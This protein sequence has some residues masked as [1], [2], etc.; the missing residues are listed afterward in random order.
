MFDIAIATDASTI[1]V[2]T[3]ASSNAYVS[4]NPVTMVTTSRVLPLVIAP[5]VILR[6]RAVEVDIDTL[7]DASRAEVRSFMDAMV[8]TVLAHD[9]LGLAAPQV[10]VSMRVIVYRGNSKAEPAVLINPVIVESRGSMGSMEGCLSIPGQRRKVKRAQT[11]KIVG[12]DRN[13]TPVSYHLTGMAACVAQHEVDHLDGR[14]MT[15][16]PRA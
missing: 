1:A 5:A 9:A 15:E 4:V 7:T 11:I 10:G 3:N 6:M 2:D 16:L 12:F 14:L 8:A 13:L